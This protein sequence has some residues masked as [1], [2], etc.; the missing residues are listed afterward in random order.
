MTQQE[1]LCLAV[2]FLTGGAH[3]LMRLRRLSYIYLA[4]FISALEDELRISPHHLKVNVAPPTE[5]TK[6]PCLSGL[7]ACR[8]AANVCQALPAA[9]QSLPLSYLQVVCVCIC[10][11]SVAFCAVLA[12]CSYAFVP[13]VMQEVKRVPLCCAGRALPASICNWQRYSLRRIREGLVA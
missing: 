1:T 7:R 5:V 3:A 9:R 10:G 6:H 8:L 2:I 13:T 12:A 11:G 4:T